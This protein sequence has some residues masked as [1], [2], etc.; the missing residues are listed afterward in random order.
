MGHPVYR[1]GRQVDAAAKPPS[2]QS[3]Q[4]FTTGL[5]V[6]FDSDRLIV[7]DHAN[8]GFLYTKGVVIESAMPVAYEATSVDASVQRVAERATL[9]IRLGDSAARFASIDHGFV[10]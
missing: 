3:E 9:E 10:S 1:L 7:V 6:G 5:A 2:D 8:Q 4:A